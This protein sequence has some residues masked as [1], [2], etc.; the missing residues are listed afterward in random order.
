[1]NEIRKIKVTLKSRPTMEG[2]G[3]RLKRAFGYAD[4]Y[5]E[6]FLLLE[7]FHSD[8]PNDYWDHLEYVIDTAESRGMAVVLLPAWGVYVAG[9]WGSG[10]PTRGRRAAK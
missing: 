5:V 10:K 4:P 7:D 6:P 3:V 8:N 2:A 1:M 9:D